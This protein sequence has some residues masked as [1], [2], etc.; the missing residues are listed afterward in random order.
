MDWSVE[1]ISRGDKGLFYII[2]G[3]GMS[4]LIFIFLDLSSPFI[5]L[6]S[7]PRLKEIVSSI[8]IFF[9]EDDLIDCSPI[10]Q[11]HF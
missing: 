8:F 9:L 6:L 2:L 7:N 11:R 3:M 10:L 5:L 1:P 4:H